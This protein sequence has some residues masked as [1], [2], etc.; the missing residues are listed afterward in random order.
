MTPL[1]GSEEKGS[2][3]SDEESDE[4]DEEDEEGSVENEEDAVGS[5][6]SEKADV[7]GKLRSNKE[8]SEIKIDRK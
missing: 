4:E 2:L 1:L 7:E 5:L 6:G 3:G 8:R